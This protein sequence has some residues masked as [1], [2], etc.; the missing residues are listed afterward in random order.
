VRRRLFG[1][2]AHEV[3]VIGAWYKARIVRA[4]VISEIRVHVNRILQ[5]FRRDNLVRLAQHRLTPLDV[6]GLK[7][8]AEV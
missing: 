6:E 8:I 2:S 3:A 4:G 1:L 5:G 7:E